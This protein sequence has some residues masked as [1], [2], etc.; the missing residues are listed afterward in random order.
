MYRKKMGS[1]LKLVRTN[2]NYRVLGTST[3]A[4]FF[5]SNDHYLKFERKYPTTECM[6]S[7]LNLGYHNA[8]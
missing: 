4:I 8:V 7:V 3:A 1:D 2:L 5:L 6:G